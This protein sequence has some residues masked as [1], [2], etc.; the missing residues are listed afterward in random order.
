MA[1]DPPLLSDE[2]VPSPPILDPCCM[3]GNRELVTLKLP[4]PD[5]V[6]L[7]VVNEITPVDAP[8]ATIATSSVPVFDITYA[9]TP[10]IVKFVGADRPVPFIVTSV[11]TEPLVGL[12]EVIA[13]ACASAL[14]VKSI[15]K[16]AGRLISL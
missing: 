6:P 4:E 1:T 13:G 9:L 11:P 8:G 2:P 15:R 5:A 7:L 10:P 3:F 16:I 12:N 14:A